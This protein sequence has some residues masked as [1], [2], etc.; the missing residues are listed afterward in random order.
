M[1]RTPPS[2]EAIHLRDTLI[3]EE[4]MENFRICTQKWPPI[5]VALIL[6]M[7][8][9]HLS[10]VSLAPELSSFRPK[11]YTLAPFYPEWENALMIFG[12]RSAP[13]IIEGRQ[14]YRMLSCVFL[15]GD[16][17]HLTL[18]MVALF[19]L[20]RLCEAIYGKARFLWLVVFSGLTGSAASL[21][22]AAGLA[23][24]ASGAVFGLLGAGIVFGFRY[25]NEL[26][27]PLKR[28]FG[29]G[30]IPWVLLNVVIGLNVP[31]I[32]NLGHMGGFIGG[33]V[34]ALI[35]GNRVIRD[36]RGNTSN[37][38]RLLAV[39]VGLIAYTL[40]RMGESIRAFL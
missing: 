10:A 17:M 4:V 23:V 5:T 15:H 30:L 13:E 12:A 20:G 36:E 21:G 24:G 19:G 27:A 16:G 11:F 31:R 26:P 1:K 3:R 9:I 35:M 7:V 2:F 22:G 25:R 39:S 6:G 33:A 34:L 37:D 18:N 29:R 40:L 14:Y 32:D 28:L 8:A 38:Q